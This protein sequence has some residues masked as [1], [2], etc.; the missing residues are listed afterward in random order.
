[1]RFLKPIIAAAALATML[2]AAPVALAQRGQAASVVALDYQRVVTSSDAG[3]DL[4]TKL[5]QV[6]TQIQGE[7]QPEAQAIEQEQRNIQQ[8]TQGMT[9]EQVRRNAELSARVEAFGQRVEQFRARQVTASHDLD[10]TRQQALAEFNRLLA[11]SVQEA[12][13]A[14]NAGIVVDA[15]ATQL[16]LPNF[17]ITDDVVQRANQR[18]RT[19]NVTRQ[20]APAQQQQQ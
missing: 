1:M 9:S 4:T 12:M 15:G 6:A 7:L 16:V 20:S 18:V 11:P 10:Y 14:R 8:A 2:A 13:E 19:V 3:R 5:G 17:D